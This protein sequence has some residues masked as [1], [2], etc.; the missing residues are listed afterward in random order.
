MSTE[1]I[2]SVSVLSI[3]SVWKGGFMLAKLDLPLIRIRHIINLC[4]LFAITIR[5]NPMLT[6]TQITCCLMFLVTHIKS[7]TLECVKTT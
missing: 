6:F 7:L 5:K 4:T 3:V 1:L 2:N